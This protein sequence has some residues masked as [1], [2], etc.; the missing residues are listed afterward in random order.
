MEIME[1]VCIRIRQLQKEHNLSINGLAAE[2]VLNQS[3]L[4]HVVSGQRDTTSIA[5]I[6]K[7]CDG[8]GL[9]MAAFFDAEVFADVEILPPTQAKKNRT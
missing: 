4:Q 8:L 6:Q 7:L 2:C 5:T 9:D 1:A 3:T